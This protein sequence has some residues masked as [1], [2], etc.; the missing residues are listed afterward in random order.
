ML[1]YFLQLSVR[2]KNKR[3]MIEGLFKNINKSTN[4]LLLSTRQEDI[5]EFFEKEKV[6]LIDYHSA[7]KDACCKADKIT[8]N[9]KST[10]SMFK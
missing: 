7:V 10:F 6:F 1:I 2:G 9:R 5:D 4:E 8:A 3:E